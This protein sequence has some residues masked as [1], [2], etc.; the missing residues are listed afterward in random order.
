MAVP[1]FG[2]IDRM[3]SGN[4]AD[5]QKQ[6]TRLMNEAKRIS[7][8]APATPSGG[9]APQRE[10]DWAWRGG[11]YEEEQRGPVIDP[12][13]AA[14]Q[15]AEAARLQEMARQASLPQSVRFGGG[16]AEQ[17]TD[18]SWGKVGAGVGLNDPTQ[19]N[20]WATGLGAVAANI[21]G[22]LSGATGGIGRDQAG[23]TG[24]DYP[25]LERKN[26]SK[27]GYE[28]FGDTPTIQDWYATRDQL[29][30]PLGGGLAGMTAA[31]LQQGRGRW[32]DVVAG[33]NQQMM[34]NAPASIDR[35]TGQYQRYLN[36]PNEFYNPTPGIAGRGDWDYDDYVRYM[37][38]SSL[39]KGGIGWADPVG[40]KFY[41]GYGSPTYGLKK[42]ST[43]PTSRSGYPKRTWG[44]GGGGGGGYSG[45]QAP[46]WVTGLMN[47]RI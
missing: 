12:A 29:T 43:K 19:P 37:V 28:R 7:Y 25:A 2:D 36:D 5:S 34:A 16:A 27:T 33:Y 21:Q 11:D 4:M 8:K 9:Y 24:A 35:Y 32:D 23:L 13:I 44:Y 22:V 26:P 31:S 41:E 15:A 40:T 14:R 30:N 10:P 38:R 6:D 17:S 18:N 45:Y 39:A 46:A 3:L 42:V 47:W 20:K 1:R